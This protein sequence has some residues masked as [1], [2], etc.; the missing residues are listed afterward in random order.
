MALLIKSFWRNTLFHLFHKIEPALQAEFKTRNLNRLVI[1]AVI[2][3]PLGVIHIVVFGV[4]LTPELSVDMTWRY[5]IFYAH[6]VLAAFFLIVGVTAYYIKTYQCKNKLVYN[7]FFVFSTFGILFAG[8]IIS[9]FDQYVTNA[10]TP[11]VLA[12]V[13]ISMTFIVHPR[14]ML[15]F[16]T[17]GTGFFYLIHARY[18]FNAD[19]FTSN[20]LNAVSISGGSFVLS[21]LLW[22]SYVERETQKMIIKDQKR[23]LENQLVLV[24]S[25]AQELAIANTSKDRFFSIIAH[26]LRNPIGSIMSLLN[27]INDKDFADSLT[28]KQLDE[29][30][31]ELQKSANNTY[32]LLENLLSWAREQAQ[33]N[34]FNPEY[35][36]LQEILDDVIS[37]ASIPI[38]QKKLAVNINLD[39][40]EALIFADNNM[41]KTILRNILGNAIK[42]S[43]VYGKILISASKSNQMIVIRIED[44][45]IGIPEA[46]R[47]LL[48]SIENNISTMGTSN[49]KGT[50]LG[51]VLCSEFM[52]R[53]NGQISIVEK[54]TEGTLIELKFPQPRI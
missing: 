3:I 31:L 32:N 15:V 44:F 24:R 27:L 42:F 5:H 7:L 10:I 25:S 36:N 35:I 8:I 46:N 47:K 34:D 39:S 41:L 52:K 45:G 4:S 21:L 9:A 54:N 14:K 43:F 37:T 30:L 20:V 2:A 38:M 50:G 48:F 16:Q 51:L 17:L 12:T 26:D 1:T 18:Q 11:F 53:H 13:F 6:I 40:S 33:S 49:E 23:Q 19:V 22:N 28:R 29:L